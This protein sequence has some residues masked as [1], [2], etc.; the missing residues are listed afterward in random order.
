MAVAA[1]VPGAQSEEQ[2]LL[3]EASP[4]SPVAV[5]AEPPVALER[6]QLPSRLTVVTRGDLAGPTIIL[7]GQVTQGAAW[8][9]SVV[10][11]IDASVNGSDV[12]APSIE[13]ALTV[14]VSRSTP[15]SMEYRG[16]YNSIELSD[17]N[18]LTPAEAQLIV[19]GMQS[20]E[21]YAFTAQVDSF[22]V[23][24]VALGDLRD[25]DPTR[26]ALNLTLAIPEQLSW[27]APGQPLGIGATWTDTQIF[28]AN[29]WTSVF[30]R[31]FVLVQIDGNEFSLEVALSEVTTGEKISGTSVGT[32]SIIGDV[33]EALP[34]SF[35][36]FVRSESTETVS[37]GTYVF[38]EEIS[39]V[40]E[41]R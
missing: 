30:E 20:I 13:A 39:V 10:L 36:Q 19:D 23:A 17:P 6:E 25:I 9:G 26:L 33:T 11:S 15:D 1:C 8:N 38:V 28:E 3:E 34:L 14:D 22:G 7:H 12:P 27:P 37:A 40:L 2:A 41:G 24:D 32:G 35:E 16:S 5:N 18:D 29:G 4:D 31:T 21:E